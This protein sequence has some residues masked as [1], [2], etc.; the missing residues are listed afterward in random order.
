MKPKKLGHLDKMHWKAKLYS[1]YKHI[2]EINAI[3]K[4]YTVGARTVEQPT[5]PA[6]RAEIYF[7]YKRKSYVI[8]PGCID[9]TDEI[10][11]VLSNDIIDDLY[12]VGAYCMFYAGMLD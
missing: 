11:E 4:K 6:K 10:F 9:T 7:M 12:R 8:S 2:P 1:E 5:W 3:L